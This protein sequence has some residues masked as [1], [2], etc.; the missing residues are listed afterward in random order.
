MCGRTACTLNPHEISKSTRYVNSNGKQVDP[1]W[2]KGDEDKYR[3]SYNKAPMSFCP[4][5]IHSD[6]LKKKMTKKDDDSDEQGHEGVITLMKWG[7]VPLWVKDPKQ[8]QYKMNNARSDTMLSKASYKKPLEKG[9]RCVVLAD[10]FYEWNTTKTEKQPYFIYFKNKDDYKV[11]SEIKQENNDSK[12]DLEEKNNNV[13][14]D[15]K[16]S[17]DLQPETKDKEEGSNKINCQIIRMAGIFE[18]RKS[19]NDEE[20]ELFTFS[21]ITVDSHPAFGWLHHRMPAML[22]NDDQVRRWL[23]YGNVPLKEAIDL[24]APKDCLEWHPVSKLVNNSRNNS[25]ECMVKIDLTKPEVKKLS[26]ESKRMAKWLSGSI[27]KVKKESETPISED[28]S[29]TNE[30]IVNNSSNDDVIL[31][32]ENVPL[33][34]QILGRPEKKLLHEN[35]NSTSHKSPKKV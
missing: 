32:K 23:D 15:L 2:R 14:A 3:P 26:N 29:Q 6:H 19:E 25:P 34:A 28:E 22:E 20:D 4:V 7:L 27:T 13:D 33:I 17:N 5:L 16:E 11:K 24:I 31:K 30:N 9:Q 35:K 18:R 21:V 10:G 8:A 12:Y 1:K